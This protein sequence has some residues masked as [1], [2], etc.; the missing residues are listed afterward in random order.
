RAAR[1]CR[2]PLKAQKVRNLV[3]QDEFCRLR[4]TERLAHPEEQVLADLLAEGDA[5]PR[6]VL[7]YRL[8]LELA[9]VE[10]TADRSGEPRGEI[11]AREIAGPLRQ[12]CLLPLTQ[13]VDRLVE[14]DER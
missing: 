8:Q 11:T 3:S 12:R 2:G 9:Q 7:V 10:R 14:D 6:T 1:L 5:R 4:L 13:L